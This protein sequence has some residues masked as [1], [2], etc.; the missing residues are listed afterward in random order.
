MGC[1]DP[2]AC[3]YNSSATAT[4]ITITE[5]LDGLLAA[6]SFSSQ[7]VPTNDYF[8]SSYLSL[9][10][11][12]WEVLNVESFQCAAVSEP[13]ALVWNSV[14]TSTG[15]TLTFSQPANAISFTIAGDVA[16]FDIEVAHAGGTSIYSESGN[17]D[18]GNVVVL[19]ESDV[20]AL[21][22]NT[23]QPGCLDDIT[24]TINLECVYPGCIDLPHATMTL[25]QV[26]TTAR[27]FTSAQ[28][29]PMPT[30][31]TTTQRP[32]SMTA[33]ASLPRLYGYR[34]NYDATAACDDGSCELPHAQDVPRQRLQ[35]RCNGNH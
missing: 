31:A 27:E 28:D 8:A 32:P 21:T 23:D 13:N 14:V 22:F 1:T 35:L 30:P 33:R 9:T 15:A 2:T 34:R 20:T 4:S 3:N 12:T 17:G 19:A 11:G 6:G 24:F 5:N 29:V 7:T 18:S 25:L 26:A 16:A 10:N